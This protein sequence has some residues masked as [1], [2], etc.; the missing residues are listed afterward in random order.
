MKQNITTSAL[1]IVLLLALSPAVVAEEAKMN[2]NPIAK[3]IQ[4]LSELQAKVIRD[5]EAEEK[6]Y[7][8]YFEWCDDASREK[9]QEIKTLSG[10]KEE[11]AATIEKAAA[12]IDE[13]ATKIEELGGKIAVDEQ[14]LKAAT[15]IREKE[16]ANF[17]VV[18]KDLADGVD[19]L[20][21][22][23]KIL[24]KHASLLQAKGKDAKN[25]LDFEQG[26]QAVMD[27][28]ALSTHDKA[29]LTSL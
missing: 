15:E 11:L 7:K 16:N 8:D 19:A 20:G 24:E 13:L 10:E 27:A 14:D 28:A 17:V 22:A 26:M 18:E 23:I 1:A 9:Q 4:L 25:L 3:V 6:A 21:R 5:G 12:T 2:T 29:K